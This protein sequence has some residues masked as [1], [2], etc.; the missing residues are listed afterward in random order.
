MSKPYVLPKGSTVTNVAA[1]VHRDIAEGMRSAKI[2]GSGKFEG[3]AVQKDFVVSD[4]DVIEI[5]T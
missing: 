5:H 3:Q 4:G 2:W 1:M